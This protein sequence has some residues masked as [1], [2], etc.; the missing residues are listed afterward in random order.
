MGD[1][2]PLHTTARALALGLRDGLERLEKA[3][4]VR[5]G[6]REKRGGERASRARGAPSPPPIRRRHRVSLFWLAHPPSIRPPSTHPQAGRPDT[7]DLARDL[8]AKLAELTRTAAALDAAW[9]M[10]VVRQPASARDL[11]KR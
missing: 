3:T 7:A 6:E 10:A 5:E 4:A 1:L 8:A 11:W 9:R 2:Q